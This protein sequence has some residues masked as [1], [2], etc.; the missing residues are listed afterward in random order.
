MREGIKSFF[1][2]K[3]G[4]FTQQTTLMPQQMQQFMNLQGAA[5]GRGAG[6]AFGES[7][8]YYRDLLSNN[9][10]VLQAFMN[11]EMRQFREETI[12]GLAEQFAG[13]GSG[14]LSS[15]GFRNAAVSAGADLG[16]RLAAIRAQLRDAAA[17]RL[18]GIGSQALGTFAQNF[19]RPRSPGF[20]ESVA[21]AIGAGLGMFGGPALGAVGGAFGSFINKKLGM[22]Q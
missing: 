18:Q 6:G 11:P 17:Q 12:P 3:P 8:D 2:G 7:A 19:Y 13:M 10:E 20:L 16:E 21:P 9:P 5:Q 4:G 14:A 1:T 22:Q 15:S